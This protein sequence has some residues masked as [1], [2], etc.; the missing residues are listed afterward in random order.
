MCKGTEGSS[1]TAARLLHVI[2]L[3]GFVD[4]RMGKKNTTK[5]TTRHEQEKTV[6]SSPG[7]KVL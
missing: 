6:T 1:G 5:K 7:T 2:A 3:G 4:L